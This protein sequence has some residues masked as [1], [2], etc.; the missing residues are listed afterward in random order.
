MF[1]STLTGEYRLASPMLLHRRRL[2][3]NSKG[4]GWKGSP[5]EYIPTRMIVKGDV[6]MR[7]ACYL[8]NENKNVKKKFSKYTHMQLNLSTSHSKAGTGF[9]HTSCKSLKNVYIRN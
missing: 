4:K 9:S 2:S 3:T 8:Q 6:V 7:H 1:T 5:R